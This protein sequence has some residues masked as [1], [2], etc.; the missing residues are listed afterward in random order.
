M[1]DDK[2]QKQT[3]GERA[4]LSNIFATIIYYVSTKLKTY[5]LR[6]TK[7]SHQMLENK[8]LPAVRF[9]LE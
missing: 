5:T 6:L 3:L 1:M 8:N 4:T 7:G 2:N 9:E